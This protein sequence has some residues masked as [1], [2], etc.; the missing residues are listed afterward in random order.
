MKFK[1]YLEEKFT[2]DSDVM[3]FINLVQSGDVIPKAHGWMYKKN[4][5]IYKNPEDLIKD[6]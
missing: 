2:K 1:Q 5:K 4:N 6:I 3:K